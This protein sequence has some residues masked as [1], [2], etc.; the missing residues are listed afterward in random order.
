MPSCGVKAGEWF[1]D[2]ENRHLKNEGLFSCLT[3]A[4]VLEQ[5]NMPV[6]FNWTKKNAQFIVVLFLLLNG[7]P[8][9]DFPAY[10]DLMNFLNVPFVPY[11]YW[12]V[13]SGWGIAECLG[14]V[15]DHCV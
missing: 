1:R 5:L 14:E 11:K 10:K 7:R 6:E 8:M 3:K 2:K 9:V 12:S 4:T 15:V 13:N